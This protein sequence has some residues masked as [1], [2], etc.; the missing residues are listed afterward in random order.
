MD[1][2]AINFWTS[3]QKW[4]FVSLQLQCITLGYLLR[5]LPMISDDFGEKKKRKQSF[6]SEI[7]KPDLKKETSYFHYAIISNSSVR[8]FATLKVFSRVNKV[9]INCLQK[10]CNSSDCIKPRIISLTKRMMQILHDN[11]AKSKKN[12]NFCCDRLIFYTIEKTI[13]RPSKIYT[14]S[15]FKQFLPL[16]TYILPGYSKQSTSN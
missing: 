14:W 13:W 2:L 1:V 10:Y 15:N 12:R 4:A 9:K 6:C 7:W 5:I 3:Y 11:I 8:P 16:P